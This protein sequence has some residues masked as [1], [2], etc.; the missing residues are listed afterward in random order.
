MKKFLSIGSAVVALFLVGCSSDN[1]PSME[2]GMNDAQRAFV[3]AIG[4]DNNKVLFAFDSSKVDAAEARKLDA[5]ADWLC[6]NP[7]AKLIIEGHCDERGTAVYN[8]GLGKRRAEAVKAYLIAKNAG[9][10]IS[11]VSY[12]KERPEV[13]ESNPEAW[14]KNRRGVV[15]LSTN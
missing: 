13:A 7:G 3:D 15:V 9:A 11:T 2:D 12:G 6:K 14:A 4:S 5:V 1:S 8:M 10:S